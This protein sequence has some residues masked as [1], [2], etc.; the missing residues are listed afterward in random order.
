MARSRC[1]C[2]E[3]GYRQDLAYYYLARLP[4]GLGIRKQRSSTTVMRVRSRMER[5]SWRDAVMTNSAGVRAWIFATS[6]PVLIQA[7]QTVL[8]QQSAAQ[9]QSVSQPPHRQILADGSCLRRPAGD[10]LNSRPGAL[11]WTVSRF[12][13]CGRLQMNRQ[14]LVAIAFVAVA[15][16]GIVVWVWR[17]G[18]PKAMNAK[19][20]ELVE[21]NFAV[22]HGTDA[23]EA[24]GQFSRS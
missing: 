16:I 20:A 21:H 22:D 19:L 4:K 15:V 24:P 12:F 18:T 1:G 10:V 14:I 23:T 9:S 5:T 2:H 6:L 13:I 11:G 3:V 8:A 7:S 17:S